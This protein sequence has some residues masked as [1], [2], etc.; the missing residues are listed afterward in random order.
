MV[1]LTL[2]RHASSGELYVQADHGLCGPLHHSEVLADGQPRPDWPD[3]VYTFEPADL[4]W[5]AGQPWTVLATH[6]R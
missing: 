3:L 2:Q 4:D 6:D 5:A 1:N